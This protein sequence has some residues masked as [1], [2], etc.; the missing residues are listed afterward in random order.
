MIVVVA[1]SVVLI[2][3]LSAFVGWLIWRR[4]KESA[5]P[6]ERVESVESV[7]R[8]QELQPLK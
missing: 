7:V 3:G 6:Y 2:V 5:V 8:E 1:L 4:E